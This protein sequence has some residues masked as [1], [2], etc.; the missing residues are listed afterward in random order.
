[1]LLDFFVVWMLCTKL[2]VMDVFSCRFCTSLADEEQ[3]ENDRFLEECMVDN[4]L[5]DKMAILTRT[6]YNRRKVNFLF[7]YQVIKGRVL[8]W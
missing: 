1:M 3:A 5:R 4:T 6:F 8:D 2:S 7:F